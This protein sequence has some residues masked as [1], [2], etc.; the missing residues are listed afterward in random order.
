MYAFE[1]WRT[2]LDQ[3]DRIKPNWARNPIQ[4]TFVIPSSPLA[5]VPFTRGVGSSRSIA[6]FCSVTGLIWTESRD[7]GITT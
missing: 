3:E 6:L 4:E 5:I 1:T 7:S 2:A